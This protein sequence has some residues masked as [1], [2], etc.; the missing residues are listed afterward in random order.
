MDR[1]WSRDEPTS[2]RELVDELQQER[3]TAHTT[4]KDRDGQPPPGG[5]PAVM[6]VASETYRRVRALPARRTAALAPRPQLSTEFPCDPVIAVDRSPHFDSSAPIGPPTGVS[7]SRPITGSAFD[8]DVS[9]A[10]LI[11]SRLEAV[12]DGDGDHAWSYSCMSGAQLRI[13][14]YRLC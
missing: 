3:E 12:P 11:K 14:A 6:P 7:R 2:I 9:P 4:V 1:L 8:L 5:R 13:D 10:C